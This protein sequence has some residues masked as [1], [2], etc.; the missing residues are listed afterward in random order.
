MVEKTDWHLSG[1]P[2]DVQAEALKRSAGH[3][4]YGYWL[5][6]GLGK[7]P[8]VLNEYIDRYSHLDTIVVISPNSFKRDWAYMPTEWGVGG[9]FNTGYWPEHEIPWRPRYIEW[10]PTLYSINF[11]AVRG[12]CHRPIADLLDSRPCLLVVDESSAIKNFKS[13]TA[14]A[15]LD[16]AKRA[17]AVRL[18]NGTPMSQNPMDLYPQLKCLGVLN[19]VN[20]YAFR[21]RFCQ[22]G[23]YMGRQV[24]GARN[25]EELQAL[26]ARC[27]FRALKTDWSDLPPKVN[28]PLRLEMTDRQRKHYREM[29]ADFYTLV[30]MEE[31]SAPMVLTQMDKLRQIS[32]GLLID[33]KKHTL[34]DEP[35]K[36]PKIR[37]LF[38]VLDSGPGKL[39]V[40]HYYTAIGGVI[41]QELT[42]AGLNPAVIRGGMTPE[43]LAAEKARF[44]TDN[45][46]RVLV[47]QITAASRAHTLLGGEGDDRCSRM[48][49]FDQTFS[50][51][52]RQQMEDRI[53]R[54]AQDRMCLY[55]DLILSPIDDAQIQALRDKADMASRIVDA[56]RALR[57]QRG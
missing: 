38:D 41:Y 17:A 24:V 13:Q 43:D 20:P 51:M 6:Q 47:A 8:L 21:N 16:L 3:D 39:I 57:V 53:H 15:V 46:C 26:Q 54:G 22:L 44:N 55:Y 49:M 11:E 34:I 4:K 36:N 2:Y 12:S 27:S 5:E 30:G 42:E 19:K 45:N 29:L 9:E 25:E 14:R 7:S 28:V 10:R 37:A 48:V 50:L 56:V 32:S 33:G 1:N 52:D 18:L 31:Y 23:G 35:S 40:V